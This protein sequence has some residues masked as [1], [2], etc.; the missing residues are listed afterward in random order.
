[1]KNVSTISDSELI[2]DYVP[3]IN[4]VRH[5]VMC[6]AAPG[7]ICK[8]EKVHCTMPDIEAEKF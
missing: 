8:H 2:V 5:L 6:P 7:R 1:M 3:I 4:V